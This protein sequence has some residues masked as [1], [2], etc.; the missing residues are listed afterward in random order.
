[1]AFLTLDQLR[2]EGLNDELALTADADTTWGSTAVRNKFIQRAIAKLWPRMGRLVREELT[3]VVD[4]MDYALTGIYDVER[5]EVMSIEVP[6]VRGSTIR[7]WQHY[8]DEAADPPTSRLTI[9]NTAGGYTVR[10]IGYKP[11]V[12]PANGAASSDIPGELEWIVYA[13]ARVEAHKWMLAKMAN[14]E[15]FQNENRQNSLTPADVIELLR[16]ARVEFEAGI[17]DN[18]R[19]LT[20]AHRAQLGRT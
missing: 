5:L 1:M 8:M 14:F 13:G 17:R 18:A 7:G 11:Y 12:V 20:G 10:V 9:P 15:R 6:G 4:Q 2:T 3:T 19:N 16:Q